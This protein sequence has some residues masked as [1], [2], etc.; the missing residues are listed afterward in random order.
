[1]SDRRVVELH[2][3]D[4]TPDR[5]FE[6]GQDR[7]AGRAGLRDG[8]LAVV[9]VSAPRSRREGTPRL[10]ETGKGTERGCGGRSNRRFE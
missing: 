3:R 10:Q 8:N 4:W 5:D 7:L 9:R 2:K 6:I 1:M